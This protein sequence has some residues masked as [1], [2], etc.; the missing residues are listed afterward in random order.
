MQYFIHIQNQWEVLTNILFPNHDDSSL[1]TNIQNL[2]PIINKT[3]N[4]RHINFLIQG[5]HEEANLGYGSWMLMLPQ[6]NVIHNAYQ[7]FSIFEKHSSIKSEKF[8]FIIQSSTD[9]SKFHYQEKRRCSASL[10]HNYT[11]KT[12]CLLLDKC[13]LY[14]TL[15]NIL[16]HGSLDPQHTAHALTNRAVYKICHS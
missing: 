4:S 2:H 14:I 7:F 6:S 8:S 12:I 11:T 16:I 3:V 10:C 9:Q 1:Y 5:Q 15:L 13:K